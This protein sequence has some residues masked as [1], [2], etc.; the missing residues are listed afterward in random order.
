MPDVKISAFPVASALNLTDY[1]TIL[2]SGANKI[3]LL[4]VLK[5]L[6][7]EAKT[8]G[9]NASGDIVTTSDTQTLSNKTLSSPVLGGTAVTA[10]GA[11][12]NILDGATLSTAELNFLDG[13]TGNIQE[14]I[15]AIQSATAIPYLA[16]QYTN[17]WVQSGTTKTITGAT[18]LTALGNPGGYKVGPYVDVTL[19]QESG[20]TCE[21]VTGVSVKLNIAGS[22]IRYFDNIDLSGLTNTYTYAIVVT[23]RLIPDGT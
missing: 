21:T 17:S 2:Q 18:I 11:E 4:S 15:N 13:A 8:L 12:L 1:L 10:N 20:G 16:Y 6:L 5:T 19:W 9:G 3:A 23:F 22:E 14:Q 7:L